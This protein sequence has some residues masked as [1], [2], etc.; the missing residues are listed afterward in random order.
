MS[1]ARVALVAGAGGIG[2][3]IAR[4][5]ARDGAR[6][7]LVDRDARRVEEAAA[8]I[9]QALGLSADLTREDEVNGAVADVLRLCGRLDIFVH[10]VGVT[11]PSLP[12]QQVPFEEWRRTLAINL[13]SMFLCCKAVVPALLANG[14]G[15]IVNLASIAGKEGNAQQAAYSAAK[16]GAIALTK[17]LGKELAHT[18]V[19]VNAIAPA[20]IHTP[21]IEQMSPGLRA[22]VLARI[23]MGRPGL[24]HEVADMAAWLC[25]PECS[26]TTGATFDLSGGR[27]TY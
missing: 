21:L 5:L 17:S 1:E 3:A 26:F 8:G 25:S 20:V 13:D 4:R 16:A 15:R 23:P 14:W 27:A 2:E 19:R 12:L 10:T 18:Q 22:A 9:P 11:G 7:V 24:P 6:V